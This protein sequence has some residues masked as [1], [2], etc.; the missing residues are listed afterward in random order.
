MALTQHYVAVEL[1]EQTSPADL[2]AAAVLPGAHPAA[3][4]AAADVAVAVAAVAGI[5]VAVAAGGVAA[6]VVFA[7]AV[8]GEVASLVPFDLKQQTNRH[9]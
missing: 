9:K 8:V 1:Q 5:V 6:V 2:A 7:A 4:A 3:A